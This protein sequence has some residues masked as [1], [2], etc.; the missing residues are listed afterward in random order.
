MV[1]QL[2]EWQQ[3]KK[4]HATAITQHEATITEQSHSLQQIVSQSLTQYGTPVM[5]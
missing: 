4:A 2:E 3:H 5:L 1:E